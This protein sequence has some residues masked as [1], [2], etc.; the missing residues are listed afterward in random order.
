MS[1][2][3]LIILALG[4]AVWCLWLERKVRALEDERDALCHTTLRLIEG[5]VTARVVGNKVI[6]TQKDT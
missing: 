6:I 1:D 2:T 5:K 3:S 4:L